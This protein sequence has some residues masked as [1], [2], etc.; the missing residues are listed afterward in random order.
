MTHTLA[1]YVEPF[2]VLTP[3]CTVRNGRELIAEIAHRGHR[4]IAA[5]ALPPIFLAQPVTRPAVLRAATAKALAAIVQLM[6]AHLPLER[7]N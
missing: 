7:A 2:E 1:E 3:E 4:F 6:R 5:V